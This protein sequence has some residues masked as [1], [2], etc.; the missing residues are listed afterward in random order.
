[1]A[2]SAILLNEIQ[3]RTELLPGDMEYVL[4]RH[5]RLYA[6]EYGYGIASKLMLQ[7]AFMNFIDNTTRP[8]TGPG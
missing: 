7:M 3:I 6:D 8:E 2:T 5:G 4:Y 1:M